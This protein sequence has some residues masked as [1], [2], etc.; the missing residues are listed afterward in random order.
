MV[1]TSM[2]G[3]VVFSMVGASAVGAIGFVS[4][5]FFTRGMLE[6]VPCSECG[7]WIPAENRVKAETSLCEDFCCRAC[8]D[9]WLKRTSTRYRDLLGN[10]LAKAQKWANRL[11]W[12][13]NDK[14]NESHPHS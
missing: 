1:D 6:V 13:R 14:S 2:M 4:W 12:R 7:K 11:N 3:W 8:H 10:D 9:S 5:Y